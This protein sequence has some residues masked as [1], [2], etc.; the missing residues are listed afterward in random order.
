MLC[1]GFMCTLLILHVFNLRSKT[2]RSRS[3]HEKIEIC[4]ETIHAFV[5]LL[6]A[7]Y[8]PHHVLKH[9]AVIQPRHPSI[10]LW[11]VPETLGFNCVLA[12]FFVHRHIAIALACTTP[13]YYAQALVTIYMWK[14]NLNAKT[15]S[16]RYSDV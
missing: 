2:Y 10:L 5:P 1:L 3:T 15:Y 9:L 8:S 12:C 14:Y 6:L 11:V 16:F 13:L 7:L 4:Y